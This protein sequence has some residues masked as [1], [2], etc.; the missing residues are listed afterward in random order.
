MLR[1]FPTTRWGCDKA[2]FLRAASKGDID[3]V[4]RLVQS[5]R[6]DPAVEN[7]TALILASQNGHLPVVHFMLADGR[8]DPSSQN[9]RALRLASRHK[10]VLVVERLLLDPRVDANAC[11]DMDILWAAQ[12][13]RFVLEGRLPDEGETTS[14]KRT[15]SVSKEDSLMVLLANLLK[16]DEHAPIEEN[17]SIASVHTV[18]DDQNGQAVQ[19]HKCRGESAAYCTTTS[20]TSRL[21]THFLPQFY[22]F[23][24]FL[25]IV[26][27]F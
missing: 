19:I 6:V 18:E 26:A 22:F 25:F 24:I 14:S 16:L 9:H 20:S 12:F 17:N 13:G 15:L 7:N 5:D 2:E 1:S 23:R 21:E 4:V 11:E 10:H 8:V 27:S 3:T